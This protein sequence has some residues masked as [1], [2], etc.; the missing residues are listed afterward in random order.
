VDVPEAVTDRLKKVKGYIKVKGQINGFDF[1]KSLVPVK[2]AP[3]R[4]F[5]DLKMLKGGGAE[6]GK[7]ARFELREDKH[8]VKKDYPV[9]P[10]L[11]KTLKAK[12]LMTSFEELSSARKK[13]ILKYLN[14]IKTEETLMKN[15]QKVVD[16]LLRKEKNVRIP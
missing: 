11:E 6:V 8:V 1:R 15:I 4:L 12:K 7:A 13:D 3:Y 9:P 14:S 16:Q 5:V 10:M 2:D